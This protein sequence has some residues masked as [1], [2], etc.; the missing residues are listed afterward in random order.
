MEMTWPYI[1]GQEKIRLN[2]FYRL[3]ESGTSVAE[4]ARL[5]KMDYS[6]IWMKAKR[7][8]FHVDSLPESN[9]KRAKIP[10]DRITALLAE[11]GDYHTVARRLGMTTSNLR[12]RLIRNGI[13]PGPLDPKGRGRRTAIV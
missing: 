13:E 2:E 5:Y 9:R 4:I 7:F 6:T 12:I 1:P 3:M 11:V 10:L 8:G